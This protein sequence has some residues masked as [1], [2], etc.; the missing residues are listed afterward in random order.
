[1]YKGSYPVKSKQCYAEL[2]KFVIS[3]YAGNST[4]SQQTSTETVNA[5]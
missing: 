5:Y 1:M 2:Q 4:K 3:A